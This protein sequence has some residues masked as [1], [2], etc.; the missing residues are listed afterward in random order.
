MSVVFEME[1]PYRGSLALHRQTYGAGSP[2][3][4]FTAAIH[5]DEVN[6]IYALN[7][8]ANVLSVQR[9]RGTVFLMPCINVLGA[10]EGKKRWSFDDRDMN[11]AFPGNPEGAPIERIAA[12]VMSATEADVCVDVQTGSATVDEAPHARTPISGAAIEHARAAGLPVIWRRSAQKF[13]EGITGAWRQAGRTALVLR[14]GRGG[15]LD[16]G[17]A[18]ALARAIVRMLGGMGM[19]ASA[20]AVP[21]TLTTS[22]VREYRSSAG[23]FFVPEVRAGE[24]VAARTLLGWVRAPLGG[25]PIEAVHAEKSGIV[26]AVRSYPLAHARELLVRIAEEAP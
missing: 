17:A 25:N 23:G 3:V 12:A 1:S 13:D 2:S 7:V 10:E 19:I 24:R 21:T 11:A 6:G 22:E 26:L 8:V 16:I 4:A 20:E 15:V 9:P 14:A 18:Q 5:G